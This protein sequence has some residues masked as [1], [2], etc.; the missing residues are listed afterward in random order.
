MR[1]LTIL[2]LFRILLLFFWNV[3]EGYICLRF[4][5]IGRIVRAWFR[6]RYLIFRPEPGH[7]DPA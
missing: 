6:I 5:R 7:N 3:V 1:L 2:Y 4:L